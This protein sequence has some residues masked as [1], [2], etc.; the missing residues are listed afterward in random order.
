MKYETF[1]DL[2]ND[3]RELIEYEFKSRFFEMFNR[4][5]EKIDW[6]QEQ[7]HKEIDG[8]NPGSVNDIYRKNIINLERIYKPLYNY[9]YDL[10]DDLLNDDRFPMV[11]CAKHKF[12]EAAFPSEEEIRREY[13]GKPGYREKLYKL[14]QKQSKLADILEG[15]LI[16]SYKLGCKDLDKEPKDVYTE[17]EEFCEAEHL[18][19]RKSRLSHLQTYAKDTSFARMMASIYEMGFKNGLQ[20]KPGDFDNAA[21][22][23]LKESQEF[24]EEIFNKE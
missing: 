7:E 10:P 4:I 19:T 11:M 1:E 14:N 20:E 12:V 8:G 24:L 22:C 21:E 5:L 16:W 17:K 6:Y 3:N 23:G 15:V 18:Q 13:M 2:Y 9:V